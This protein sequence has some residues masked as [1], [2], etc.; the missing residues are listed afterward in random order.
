MGHP[1]IHLLILGWLPH[2]GCSEQRCFE[3]GCPLSSFKAQIRS[4][5]SSAEHLRQFSA[6]V[7]RRP[8]SPQL[9]LPA[10]SGSSCSTVLGQAFHF[11]SPLPG[12][13]LCPPSRMFFRY[14]PSEI[15]FLLG[16]KQDRKSSSVPAS[17]SAQG[18]LR[19]R[20]S[21][22]TPSGC[23]RVSVSPLGSAPGG[24][25]DRLLLFGN[26]R[27]SGSSSLIKG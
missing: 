25:A 6:P 2:S 24:W 17:D 12:S 14:L 27:I 20:S 7:A 4:R 1:C 15:L 23:I 5:H 8:R 11:Q 10:L 18:P 22:V 9:L 21:A 26:P 3:C 13:M 16:T 19:I